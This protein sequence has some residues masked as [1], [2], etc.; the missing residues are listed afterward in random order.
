MKRALALVLVLGV[1]AVACGK[2]TLDAVDEALKA[3][4]VARGAVASVG[5][6]EAE[7]DR[8]STEVDR[9]TATRADFRQQIRAAT[10]DLKTSI[11]ELKRSLSDLEGRA[12]S[13]S[14][15]ADAALSKAETALQDLSVLQNR[16]D[17]HL[18]QD[19]GGG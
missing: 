11:R 1:V 18:R 8:L 17:Y 12:D 9:A 2:Q 16:Y 13:A 19:H 4:D 5:D 7:V 14:A 3:R 10:K 6:L 15:T